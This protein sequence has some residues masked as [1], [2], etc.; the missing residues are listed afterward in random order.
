MTDKI[1]EELRTKIIASFEQIGVDVE[2]F[3]KNERYEV[4]GI[5]SEFSLSAQ[6]VVEL[7]MSGKEHQ[8]VVLNQAV[9]AVKRRRLLI[10]LGEWLGSR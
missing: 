5:L 3:L 9:E 6:E 1:P 8:R 7:L 2:N 10:E 4:L